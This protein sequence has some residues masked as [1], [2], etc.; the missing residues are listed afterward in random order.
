MK[1]RIMILAALGLTLMLAGCG[2]E[3]SPGEV[4]ENAQE[5]EVSGRGTVRRVTKWKRRSTIK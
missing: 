2:G 4:E 5:D 3:T 1:K